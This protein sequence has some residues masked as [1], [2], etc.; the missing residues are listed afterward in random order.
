MFILWAGVLPYGLLQELPVKG[1]PLYD[2]EFDK[3]QQ[4]ED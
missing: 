1:F 4:D 3:C 2:G